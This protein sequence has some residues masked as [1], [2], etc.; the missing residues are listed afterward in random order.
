MRHRI[1]KT[2]ALFLLLAALFLPHQDTATAQE[3]IPANIDFQVPASVLE[4]VDEGDLVEL[5]YQTLV[6]K[7]A[8]LFANVQAVEEILTPLVGDVGRVLPD[9]AL[10]DVAAISRDLQNA[11]EAVR[12]SASLAEGRQNADEFLDLA[13]GGQGAARGSAGAVGAPQRGPPGAGR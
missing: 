9:A 8:E 4:I 3:E 7:S 12:Q 10:P 13:R 1:L 5:L 6:W 11:M 2:P